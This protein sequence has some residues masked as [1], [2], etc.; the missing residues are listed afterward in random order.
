MTLFGNDAHSV[1][2]FNTFISPIHG[3]IIEIE[4][5]DTGKKTVFG[6]EQKIKIKR[7]DFT[8]NLNEIEVL[9]KDFREDDVFISY[10]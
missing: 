10:V 2:G 6:H 3:K 8:G 1:T 7:K 9:G 4:D 5:V